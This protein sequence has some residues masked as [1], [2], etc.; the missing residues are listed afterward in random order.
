MHWPL[1]RLR[2][3]F[4]LDCRK[5]NLRNNSEGFLKMLYFIDPTYKLLQTVTERLI[6]A[7]LLCHKLHNK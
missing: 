4:G 3:L 1:A 5:L 6:R 2:A 7:R